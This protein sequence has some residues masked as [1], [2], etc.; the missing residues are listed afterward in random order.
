MGEMGMTIG[1]LY[2]MTPRQFQNKRLGFQRTIEQESRVQWETTRWLAAVTIAPHT[3]KRIKPRD[4]ILFPWE[5]KRKKH[6][7][8][9]FE[10]VKEAIKKVFG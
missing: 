8:A 3:K 9:T 2:D 1:Q 5:N 7:A 10:E 4:L 6:K